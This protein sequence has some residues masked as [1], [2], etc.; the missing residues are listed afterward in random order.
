MS[1]LDPD[2]DPVCSLIQAARLDYEE[3]EDLY[4]RIN[5]MPTIFEV[6]TGKAKASGSGAVSLAALRL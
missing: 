5:R 3:R 4:L 6:V 1:I 2:A